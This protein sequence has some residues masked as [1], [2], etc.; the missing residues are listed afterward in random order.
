MS[1][2]ESVIFALGGSR[3]GRQSLE[4]SIRV[5]TLPATGQNLMGISLMTYVPDQFVVWGVK[6]VM[7]GNGEFDG[8]QRGAQ[9]PGIMAEFLDDEIAQLVT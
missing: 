2:N 1:G 4:L 3:E 7:K 5:E 8:A 9:M 6:N